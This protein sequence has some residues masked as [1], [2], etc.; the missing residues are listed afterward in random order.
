ML[1]RPVLLLQPARVLQSSVLQVGVVG[2]IATDVIWA[3]LKL[4]N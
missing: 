1:T 4:A 2:G 3:N